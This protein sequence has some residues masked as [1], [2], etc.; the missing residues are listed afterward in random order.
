MVVLRLRQRPVR[1]SG[2]RRV[3]ARSGTAA[4]AEGKESSRNSGHTSRSLGNPAKA[5]RAERAPM[6]QM[7]L[8][9]CMLPDGG[10]ACKGHQ[11]TWAELVWSLEA[12]GK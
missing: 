4:S 7:T 3:P 12:H 8:P 9:D 11:E 2:L 1:R 6:K 10:D 5:L